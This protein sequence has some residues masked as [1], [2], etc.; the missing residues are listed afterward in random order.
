MLISG[1][2][3]DDERRADLEEVRQAGLRA[4][5]L[6][7]QLLAFSRRQVMEPAVLDLN[8]VVVN[9]TKMIKRL[10]G[11]HVELVMD[12]ASDLGQVNADPGQI[13]QVVLNLAVN[14]RDAMTDGGKLLIE[15]ANTDLDKQYMGTHAPVEPGAYVMLAVS[16]TG[17][18]MDEE[19]RMRI[20]EPFFTTKESGKGTGLGL[21]TVYG[22]IKQSN[23]YIW[24]YSEPGQGTT[25]KVYL[26]RVE[27]SAILPRPLGVV[28]ETA[29]LVEDDDGVR[30]VVR[31]T[32]ESN[33]Y[34]VVEAG[35]AAE[36]ARVAQY[37]EGPI[38]FLITDLIMPETSGRDLAQT[39]T[40]L[41]PGIRVL[42]MSGYSDNAVLRHGMLSPDMEFIAKP[43]T[44]ELLLEKVRR[45]L[46]TPIPK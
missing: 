24:V 17:D 13:E 34:H 41:R 38:D 35:S 20:F 32:L 1:T 9:V 33:G 44:Q 8:E 12:L 19:T 15:T 31:K 7:R 4:A 28:S 14:A 6:T 18:G 21:S 30:A 5:A 42:Y 10:I 2:D 25:L 36:A 45:V 23:G 22:I 40:A 11:E 46:D 16:D 3:E 27:V 29:L 39:V 37:Y 26:P 43:F